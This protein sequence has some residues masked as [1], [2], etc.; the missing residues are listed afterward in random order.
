IAAALKALQAKDETRPIYL[1][2][3]TEVLLAPEA[4]EEAQYYERDGES[5]M[6]YFDWPLSLLWVAGLAVFAVAVWRGS[7]RF[8]PV[9][10]V[11]EDRLEISKL[12]AIDAKARLIRMS[13]N[14]GRMVAEFVHTRL[15][16]LADQTF[17]AGLGEAG[18]E[19]LYAKFARANPSD[20]AALRDHATAMMAEGQL[21]SPDHRRNLIRFKE[22]LERLTH[23][24]S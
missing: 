16:A 9:R 10:V 3:S 18:I 23:G 1:D 22:L 7:V 19:R 5:L 17:G 12:A 13:Q 20:A 8:G 21:S 11:P 4:D 2:T 6:R 24:A 14:D 15:H